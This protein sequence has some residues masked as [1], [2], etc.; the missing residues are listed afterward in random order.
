MTGVQTCALPISDAE[1]DFGYFMEIPELNQAILGL[2][3][4]TIGKG[5]KTDNLTQV[6]LDRMSG[7]GFD[8]FLKILSNVFIQK[9]ALGDGMAE[10][11]RND[12]GTLINLKPL[13]LG[14]MRAVFDEKGILIR[15]EQK[16]NIKGK[17][18]RKLKPYQVLHLSNNRIGNSMHGT[19][20]IKS[21]KWVIDARNEALRDYRKVIHRNV[22]PVR[23]IEIDTDDS[24]KRDKLI[25]E[26][27][28]AINKGEV[29]VLP[30]G[31]AEIKDTTI[32]ITDPINWIRYLEDFFYKA[33]G[34][35]KIV[36][37][38]SDTFT[39][40]SSKIG[41]LTFEQVYVKEQKEIED[42]LWNQL[43][44][45]IKFNKPV[46]LK[47]E[48]QQDEIKNTGQTKIQPNEATATANRNE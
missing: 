30:K 4:W 3:L 35:P 7:N 44:I 22:I 48:L 42:Q 41:Y 32:T 46:G 33:V 21:V 19:R 25:S 45:R 5:F 10:V 38:G 20:I 36:L 17:A 26:Y 29:L 47:D 37:G 27:E 13:W 12:K 14:D 15:Y 1:E 11:I 18:N 6:K 34:I 23:I 2:D 28:D 43:A 40:A 9:K 39:E 16:S 31:T 8:T 24:T